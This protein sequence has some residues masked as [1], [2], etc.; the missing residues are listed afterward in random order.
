MLDLIQN[1]RDRGIEPATI[2]AKY[3]RRA[4]WRILLGQ[5]PPKLLPADFAN[6]EHCA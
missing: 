2:D 1:I 3:W 4:S 6:Q 5:R